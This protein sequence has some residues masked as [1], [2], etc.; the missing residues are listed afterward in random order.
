MNRIG[1]P[2]APFSGRA[3][4]RPADPRRAPEMRSPG[5][6]RPFPTV[7]AGFRLDPPCEFRGRA[8]RALGG[9]VC[10]GSPVISRPPT[11]PRPTA[12][13]PRGRN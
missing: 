5:L 7:S 3:H 10:Q 12:A 1:T 8:K 11:P 4:Q 13:A 6:L 9:F 2:A